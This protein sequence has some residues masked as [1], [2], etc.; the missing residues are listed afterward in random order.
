MAKILQLK[1]NAT[2]YVGH[3]AA[4]TAL[5]NKL[6]GETYVGEALIARY[7]PTVD[8]ND[9]RILFG[10]VGSDGKYEIFD[11]AAAESALDEAIKDLDAEITSD[12][13]INVQVKVTEVDGKITA[14]N[15]ITDDTINSTDLS[16]VINGLD[17][18]ISTTEPDG[19][20]YFVL[21]GITEEDGQLTNKTEVKLSA[22][23]KTGN[24]S[25]VATSDIAETSSRVAVTGEN[26]PA[27]F[28]SLATTLKTVQDNAAKYKSVALTSEEIAELPGAV[29]IK[30]AYKIVSY[31]GEES[32][33]TEY[34]QVGDT[35]KIYKDSSL[36]NFYLG[37]VDDVLTNA[38]AQG[39]SADTEVTT[40]TGSEA[41]VY[42]MQLANG[43]YKLTAIDVE[44][45]LNE[46]EFKDGLQVV[47]NEVSVKKD[48]AS[49]KVRTADD[50]TYTQEEYDEYVAEH[51]ESPE[52]NVGDVKTS[53]EVDVI[54][55][56]SNGVKIDNIQSA[57]D[58]A[59]QKLSVSAQ[60]D[61]YITATVD[62]LNNKT[63]KVSSDV[64]TLTG[65][66]GTA[67]TY[68]ADGAEIVAPTNGTLS[69]TAESLVDG[70]DVA[71]KV[72]DYVDGQ[73]NIEAARSD[74]HT[75]A[76]IKALDVSDVAIGGEYVSQ[77]TEADGKISVGRSL[78]GNA[79][80]KGF[81]QDADA[82]GDISANDTITD[83]L[84]K[85][86]NKADNGLDNVSAGNGI[87]VSG[88]AS[89]SQTITA[90]AVENDPIIEVTV[91][92]IG[93]KENA[94]WDCGEY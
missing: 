93:S 14:V 76:S 86:E 60:G 43:K 80:I 47:D 49:G 29:N 37:H 75:L 45:F 36:V 63:I 85:L 11:N 70:A 7:K 48:S 46:A 8:S 71:S 58:Y 23:A 12:D 33:S 5:K 2:L 83:A 77:V 62:P 31:I 26:V 89:K 22:V 3:D 44:D 59:S 19:D 69:G 73:L 35:I 39:E 25:D 82:S 50:V 68:D 24:A 28:E 64:K 54:T 42:I 9:E 6:A 10:L 15:I 94:F 74:A 78:V 84:N 91:N 34:T 30:D 20:R 4:L 40:G 32:A 21:T 51:G 56:S 17:S 52:W 27:Q 38:D 88:K 90:V 13:G 53:G 66:K 57:I 18:T 81:E 87:S 92:G 65:T 67:G 72:K 41:L 55:I 79:V 1:R 61:E 16:N